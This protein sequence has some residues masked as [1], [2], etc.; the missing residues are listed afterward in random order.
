MQRAGAKVLS[1]AAGE[2]DFPTPSHV[3]A[4]ATDA[5]ARG[6]TR[7]TDVDGIAEL[8]QAVADK[9]KRE[10]G[11]SY[12]ISQINVSPGGKAVIFNAFAATLNPGDEVIVPAPYWV[13]YPDIVTLVGAQPVVVE[14]TLQ[15]GFRLTPE[16]LEAAI[17]PRTRW[18]ILNS[19]SNP[20]GTVYSREEL[21][22]LAAVL[23][24]HPQIF[25]LSDDIYEHILFD[26]RQFETMAAAEPRMVD[27]TLTLNGVSKAYSMTGWRI[28]FAGG[29]APLIKSMA[30]VMSHTTTN[31]CS[32]SQWAALA[33]LTGPQDH[34]AERAAAFQ[35]RRDLALG[36]LKDAKGLSVYNPQ[37]AFYI[38]A[39]C[40]ALLGGTTAKGTLIESDEGFC[41]ALLEEAL[42]AT[43]PGSAFGSSPWLRMSIA[44]SDEDI[45]EACTRMVHF[46]AGITRV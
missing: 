1:M 40:G 37:G 30:K 11:L 23:L 5:M 45:A 35:R 10:N 19:P 14:T 36:I 6:E 27:R 13:S 34:I 17:T 21:Q 16:A 28:G 31:P 39:G 33:A 43:V 15:H 44:A 20:T 38:F 42:V 7:Y 22:A 25:V 3:I 9:F 8:K 26:G 24:Q 12:D 2:P 41:A 4:A 18:I 29:P 32:I 46:C